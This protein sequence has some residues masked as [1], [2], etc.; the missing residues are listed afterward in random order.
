ME[1]N[2]WPAFMGQAMWWYCQAMRSPAECF[3]GGISVWSASNSNKVGGIP[4]QVSEFGILVEPGNSSE[5]ANAMLKILL[6]KDR[7]RYGN[8]S[9]QY[10][11]N[12]FGTSRMIDLHIN[13]YKT[14]LGKNGNQ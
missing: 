5:L 10:A 4:E 13:W 11:L 2:N 7:Y 6:K 1:S 14:M 3:N 9:R 12:K 8:L